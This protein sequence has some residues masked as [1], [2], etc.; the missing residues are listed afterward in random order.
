[1]SHHQPLKQIVIAISLLFTTS[2]YADTAKLAFDIPAEP[3]EQAVNRIAKQANVQVLIA[4]N[5]AQ[6][7]A[8]TAL[9][10][11]FTAQEALERLLAGS[12][13]V[14]QS[15][16][17][18]S[19]IITAA[20]QKTSVLPEISTTE[21]AEHTLEQTIVTATRTP[22]N[23]A[24]IA[25]TVQTISHEE[26]R[27]QAAVGRKTADALAQLIPSLAPSSGTTSNYG[28][29]MRGRQVLVMIDGVS[30]TGSR[31]VSR[32]LNSISPAMIERVEVVSGAS[33][34][35]GSGATGGIINIITKRT[36][37]SKPLSFQ[38]KVGVAS[39]T[40]FNRD[41]LAYELGQ[42]VSFNQDSMD[43]FLGINY[44]SRGDQIDGNGNRIAP[45]PAQTSRSDTD[46]IDINGRLNFKL[47]NLQSLSVGVQYFKD[48]Q[49]TAYAPDYSG[50]Y[51]LNPSYRAVKGLHLSKQ[52][53]TERYAINTQYQNKDFLGQILNI[54]A[55]YRKEKARFFPT[56]FTTSYA[57]QSQSNIDVAGFRSTMQ[58][59][60][61]LQGK[62][63]TLTY[64]LDYDHEKDHQYIDVLSFTNLGTN[65]TD[66]GNQFDAGPDTTVQNLGTFLQSAFAATEKLNIQ[67]GV[68]YQYIRA[69]TEAFIP[70]AAARNAAIGNAANLTPV[71]G[72]STSAG[73]ALFN[74]GAVYKLQAGQQVFANFSQGFSYPDV[75]RIMR[76]VPTGYNLA[77]AN[78]TPITV[79]SYELGWRLQQPRG[80]NT[81]IT[82]FFNDSNKVV[83]F[84]ANRTIN[85]ASTDQRIYGVELNTSYPVLEQFKVGGTLGYTRGQ[86]KDAA[87]EWRELNAYQIS[88]IKATLFGEWDN[89]RGSGV[90]V[91]ML[92]IKGTNEAYKDALVAT[93]DSNV[94]A[95]SAAEIKGYALIDVLAHFPAPKGRIDVGVYNL[96]DKYYRTV[97]TQQAAVTFGRISSIPAEGRTIALSYTIDY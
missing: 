8:A 28:Q 55:Y 72:G 10:G 20:P 11:N 52:A 5:L 91:Q 77:S 44:T 96:F 7:I 1:M 62:E 30:Q 82:A 46:T 58:S 66:T 43:G 17:N 75:Q 45:D 88:P 39:G 90:R 89:Q 9:K 63:L 18:N 71:D 26:I 23:I 76:D 65:Y 97:Y 53:F 35:Y 80:L 94:V 6:G 2:I 48:E 27:Q 60:L 56:L 87:G 74:L 14:I 84:Q 24:E 78:I 81:G 50:N 22:K 85:V 19:F 68:R 86:F 33:S 47:D 40:N 12:E 4:S 54:E 67:A 69:K 73:K 79:N 37:K 31:D 70:T 21:Q 3:L 93:Y 41:G 83:Q 15:K 38:S 29:T 51:L 95:N 59:D 36:D 64:G 34:I 49:D 16:G 61:Q 42:T 57:T 25:G 13:L 32:Q 92:A